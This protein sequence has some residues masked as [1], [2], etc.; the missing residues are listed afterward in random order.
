M[1]ES[2]LPTVVF[3]FENGNCHFLKWLKMGV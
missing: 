1:T 2:M 3:Y